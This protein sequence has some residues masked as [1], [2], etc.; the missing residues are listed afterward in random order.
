MEQSKLTFSCFVLGDKLALALYVL[1]ESAIPRTWLHV[2][3]SE[4]DHDAHL[5]RQYAMAS[6]V[7]KDLMKF[8]KRILTA[9]L[10]SE[11]RTIGSRTL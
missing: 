10:A 7:D 5:D 2:Y 3:N 11:G 6:T 1:S 8:K 4:Y 9:W